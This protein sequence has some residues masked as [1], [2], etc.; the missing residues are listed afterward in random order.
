MDAV[1]I[2]SK[3]IDGS[4]AFLNND[5]HEINTQKALGF[6]LPDTATGQVASGQSV[7]LLLGREGPLR[8][9]GEKEAAIEALTVQYRAARHEWKWL[10][11]LPALSDAGIGDANEYR[12]SGKAEQELT[13]TFR[14]S[15]GLVQ[16]GFVGKRWDPTVQ[17][18]FLAGGTRALAQLASLATAL[19]RPKNTD[20]Q[21]QRDL[22]RLAEAE[23][24]QSTIN[25]TS[26]FYQLCM[27]YKN[28][29]SFAIRH[30]ALE[31]F[32]A[33]KGAGG[34]SFSSPRGLY[35]HFLDEDLELL[36]K[37]RAWSMI[38][39]DLNR[40]ND[41]GPLLEKLRLLALPL[42]TLCRALRSMACKEKVEVSPWSA[43]T[44]GITSKE[45]AERIL[46]LSM[47]ENEDT[48]KV[49]IQAIQQGLVEMEVRSKALWALS[50]FTT[51]AAKRELAFLFE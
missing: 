51:D 36:N 4:A 23:N 5:A 32:A 9:D 26:P 41:A 11:S 28:L 33:S 49:S 7:D 44:F 2:V 1:A 34:L 13:L 45:S 14:G 35:L 20:A 48:Q 19:F 22:Y 17:A 8:L 37:T 38:E 15:I 27:N 24:P 42:Q 10:I 50:D 46:L 18:E 39:R 40:S 43:T 16:F 21:H 25:G 47:T 31:F 6:T 29:F 3:G 30:E 12:T